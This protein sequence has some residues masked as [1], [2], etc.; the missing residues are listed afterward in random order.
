LFSFLVFLQI[1]RLIKK[2]HAPAAQKMVSLAP[3]ELRKKSYVVVAH[4]L[5]AAFVLLILRAFSKRVA[6]KSAP[7]YFIISIILLAP[8]EPRPLVRETLC[9]IMEWCVWEKRAKRNDDDRTTL[10]HETHII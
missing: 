4:V 5:M 2:F 3:K 10:A 8:F 6:T 1:S 9:C 7:R